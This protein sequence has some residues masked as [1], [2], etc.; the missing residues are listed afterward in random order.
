MSVILVSIRQCRLASTDCRVVVPI[1]LNTKMADLDNHFSQ[2]SAESHYDLVSASTSERN[3][4]RYP[5]TLTHGGSIWRRILRD[6]DG[7]ILLDDQARPLN[8]FNPAIKTMFGQRVRFIYCVRG[9][10]RY[11]VTSEE[12]EKRFLIDRD[13]G[14]IIPNKSFVVYYDADA[15]PLSLLHKRLL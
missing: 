9:E 11:I 8:L 15:A 2:E 7:S 5:V 10:Y 4:R 3:I 6:V 14:A 13:F 12:Q 1:L